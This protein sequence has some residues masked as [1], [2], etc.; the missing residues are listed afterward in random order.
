MTFEALCPTAD[1]TRALGRRLASLLGPGDIILLSGGLGAGKTVFASGLGEGL[2]VQEPLVSPTFVIV[3]H[4]EGLMPVVHA[5]LYRVGSSAEIEDLDLLDD[6]AE[7]AL[8]VEWGDAAEK[9]FPDDH[10]LVRFD[11]EKDGARSIL[12]APR[13]SWTDRPLAEVLA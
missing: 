3:R 11:V 6:A 2:G 10:L 9:V 8:I 1:E 12:L 13:G 5:D 4:Y 7:G